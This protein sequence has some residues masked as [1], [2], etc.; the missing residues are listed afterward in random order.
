MNQREIPVCFSSFLVSLASSAMLHLGEAPDP[1]TRTRTVNLGLA[2]N[3]IDVLGLLK[4]KTEGNL[5]NE[6]TKLIET[7]LYE[8]RLKFVEASQRDAAAP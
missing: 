6:E 8:L 4:A 3:T 5:D 1:V 7:L 2:R